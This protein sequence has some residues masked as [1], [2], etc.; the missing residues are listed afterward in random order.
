MHNSI[1]IEKK[2]HLIYSTLVET[3]FENYLERESPS[4]DS[5]AQLETKVV[6]SFRRRKKIT[7]HRK[8]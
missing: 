5:M 7:T 6:K 2:I 4:F 8:N 1:K 3:E